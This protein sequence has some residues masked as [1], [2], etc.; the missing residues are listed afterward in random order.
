MQRR[1]AGDQIDKEALETLGRA[2]PKHDR[3]WEARQRKRGVVATYRGIP[4][5]LQERI[6][7]IAHEHQVKIGDVA[8]RFLEYA[9]QAYDAGDLELK[10]VV[11]STTKSLYPD[12]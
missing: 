7:E 12:D 2:G 9:V 8:R 5:E 1:S 4:P 6:K 11:V 10:A 3:E